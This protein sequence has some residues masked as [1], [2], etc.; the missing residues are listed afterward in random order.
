MAKLSQ[1]IVHAHLDV[2]GVKSHGRVTMSVDQR[3]EDNEVPMLENM[4]LEL[5]HN[6][7]DSGIRKCLSADDQMNSIVSIQLTA[8]LIAKECRILTIKLNV[9]ANIQTS[10]ES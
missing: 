1:S 7:Y 4:K 8:S 3:T 5:K 9:T 6:Q 10:I 2:S